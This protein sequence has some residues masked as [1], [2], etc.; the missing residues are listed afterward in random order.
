LFFK[1][2]GLVLKKS[3]K[4][5]FNKFISNSFDEEFLLEILIFVQGDKNVD[6]HQLL[7]TSTFHLSKYTVDHTSVCSKFTVVSFPKITLAYL[8]S[9]VISSSESI[10]KND[11][12][13]FIAESSKYLIFQFLSRLNSILLFILKE[14][15]HF[16]TNK[17]SQ[18]F[19]I[20]PLSIKNFLLFGLISS[21]F[22]FSFQ[23]I[24]LIPVSMELLFT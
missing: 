16:F 20:S 3:S 1:N 5:F 10:H 19:K 22:V 14:I 12:S 18:I 7:I 23:K 24:I 17:L 8:I 21:A 6:C 13:N 4:S 11:E 2:Q 9:I 15:F